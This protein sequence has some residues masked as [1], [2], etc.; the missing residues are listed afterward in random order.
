MTLKYLP[1]EVILG[2]DEEIVFAP[3]RPLKAEGGREAPGLRREEL[4][5]VLGLPRGELLDEG[6]RGDWGERANSVT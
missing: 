4:D 2:V 1:G 5:G 6:V 3:P